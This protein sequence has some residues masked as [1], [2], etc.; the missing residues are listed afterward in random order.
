MSR[1]FAPDSLN[2]P[3]CA[4]AETCGISL[5]YAYLLGDMMLNVLSNRFPGIYSS[6]WP[7]HHHWHR[8][9]VENAMREHGRDAVQDFGFALLDFYV[10]R[11]TR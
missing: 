7:A 5:R 11:V 8:W 10:A 9:A 1:K 6:V 2:N 4:I 3:T